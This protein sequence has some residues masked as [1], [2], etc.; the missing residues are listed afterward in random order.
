VTLVPHCTGELSGLPTAP[1]INYGG[2]ALNSNP[3][4]EL[5][6]M[7]WLANPQYTP[8]NNLGHAIAARL[9]AFVNL[10]GL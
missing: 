6:E 1:G 4:Q 5:A 7:R 10:L 3:S 9:P 8:P 2:R